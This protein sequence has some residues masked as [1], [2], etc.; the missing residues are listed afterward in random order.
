MAM[1]RLEFT[2]RSPGKLFTRG[3]VVLLVLLLAGYVLTV[4]STGFMI[5]NFALDTSGIFQGKLWPLVTYPFVVSPCNL[6]FAGLIILF[7]GSV[8]EKDWGTSGLLIFWAIISAACGLLWVLANKLTGWN[9]T[10]AG[11][12]ACSYGLICMMG[13]LFKGS[14]FLFFFFPMKAEHLA[15]LLIIIGI[16]LSIIQP[17]TLIWISGAP[18][19]WYYYKL[20]RKL[21]MRGSRVISLQTSGKKDGFVD[22]D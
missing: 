14:R 4:F 5:E 15:I 6:I 1:E 3:V 2:F 19:A 10:G 12:A 22:I 9:L 13:I 16:L 18:A 21:F 7:I 11:P 8:V 20:R 17:I